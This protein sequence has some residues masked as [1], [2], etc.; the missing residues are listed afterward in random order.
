MV[1]SDEDSLTHVVL[2]LRELFNN[3]AVRKYFLAANSAPEVYDFMG[4]VGIDLGVPEGMKLRSISV[5][6]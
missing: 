3:T 4:R 6:L 5:E 2:L 1:G